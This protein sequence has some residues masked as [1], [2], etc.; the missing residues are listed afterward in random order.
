MAIV[1][2]LK[3]DR[4]KHKVSLSGISLNASHQKKAG[5][6]QGGSRLSFKINQK[7]H[8]LLEALYVP[9]TA[10]RLAAGLLLSE[11]AQFRER[12]RCRFSFFTFH[13]LLGKAIDMKNHAYFLNIR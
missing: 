1:N 10:I 12:T 6:F 7:R 5:L 2:F 4:V 13:I 11:S 3:V 9:A 8:S